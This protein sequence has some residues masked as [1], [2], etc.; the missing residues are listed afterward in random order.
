M[1]KISLL[2]LSLLILKFFD[3]EFQCVLF[4]LNTKLDKQAQ[5]NFLTHVLLTVFITNVL[6]SRLYHDRLKFDV[7]RTLLNTYHKILK[8]KL[9]NN[10]CRGVLN[11]I[12][13]D[14]L[15]SLF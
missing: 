5:L 10:P 6:I 3:T 9:L 15:V 2:E 8:Q 7:D 12:D 1:L 11:E 4:T 13:I 14:S